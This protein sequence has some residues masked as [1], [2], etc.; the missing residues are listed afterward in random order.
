[1]TELSQY[2]ALETERTASLTALEG[3][4]TGLGYLK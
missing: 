1:M 3:F 4:L 2:R